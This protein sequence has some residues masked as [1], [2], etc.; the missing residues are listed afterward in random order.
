MPAI[1]D[2]D[3][4]EVGLLV[5]FAQTSHLL[6]SLAR[7]PARHARHAVIVSLILNRSDWL[8]DMSLTMLDALELIEPRGLVLAM[9][10]RKRYERTLNS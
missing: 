9:E 1:N 10:A 5:V 2:Q 3:E 4:Q 6:D 7:L 8:W